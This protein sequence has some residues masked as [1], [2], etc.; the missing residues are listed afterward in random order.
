MEILELRLENAERNAIHMSLAELNK[1]VPLLRVRKWA[2]VKMDK[3]PRRMSPKE[4]KE[5]Q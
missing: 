1:R 3:R 4:N 5:Q 2:R